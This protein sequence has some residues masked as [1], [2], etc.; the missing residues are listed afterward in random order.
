MAKKDKKMQ[1]KLKNHRAVMGL[2]RKNHFE[3]GG[4]VAGWRGRAGVYT[5]RKKAQDKRACRGKVKWN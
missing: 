5:D 3:T 1:Q 4:D 2:M